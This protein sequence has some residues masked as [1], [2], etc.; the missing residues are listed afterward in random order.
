[1]KL[2]K[3]RG[4]LP[5]WGFALGLWL[6]ACGQGA[7][8]QAPARLDRKVPE[9]SGEPG[10]SG[11]RLLGASPESVLA[12]ELCESPNPGAA[13]LRR[14]SN[15]E[16]E[17]AVTDAFHVLD[18]S[19]TNATRSFPSETESLGFRNNAETL[20]VTRLVADNYQRAAFELAPDLARDLPGMECFRSASGIASRERACAERVISTLG[21]KLHR[22]PLGSTE[23]ERYATLFEIARG[24]GTANEAMGWVVAAFLQSPHFLYRIE[25]LNEGAE[26]IPLDDLSLASRLSFLLWQSGP[27]EELLALARDGQLGSRARIREQVDRLLR[28]ERALRFLEFFRQWFDLDSLDRIS[29]DTDLY[30]R[31]KPNLGEL[32]R[33]E[34]EAFLRDLVQ[35]DGGNLEA[36][37]AG[38]YTFANR[39]LAEHYELSDMPETDTF[40]RVEAPGRAGILTSGMLTA[41]DKATRSSIVGRG[42]K[43]RTDFLCQLVP[44]PPD[45]VDLTLSGLSPDL[46]QRDRLEQ[47]RAEPSCAG[48][49]NLM[50][51]IGVVFEGFDAVGRPRTSD[52]QGAP[53]NTRGELTGTRDSDGPLENPADLGRALAQSEEVR[54]CVM[55]QAFRYFYGRDAENPDLCSQAQL[56]QAFRDSDYNLRELIVALTTTDAFTYMAP[57]NE[58]D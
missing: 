47:H 34:S 3:Q 42:L 54:Q 39:E 17:N 37:L 51:P 24:E 9:P 8:E 33:A 15:A 31:L 40:V 36:L 55:T 22:R 32:L 11:A 49:H 58:E 13:P 6:S 23:K 12:S 56:M 57:A 2:A 18:P 44:A 30:P 28:D 26:P 46:S 52:E 7:D 20:V 43:I 38:E 48:C 4:R 50:D 14:L 1:M 25:P 16:Y 10:P 45:D 53:I 19:V 27:D 21:E 29:R 41:H 5:L 35:S